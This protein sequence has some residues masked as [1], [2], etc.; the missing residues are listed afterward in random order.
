MTDEQAEPLAHL[1]RTLEI[2]LRAEGV[3]A[4]VRERIVSRMVFGTPDGPHRIRRY[5]TLGWP[6][7]NRFFAAW[8]NAR[9]SITADPPSPLKPPACPGCGEPAVIVTG[10]AVLPGW[11]EVRPCGCLFD[12]GT[13][14]PQPS[15]GTPVAP[16]A[17]LPIDRPPE[18]PPGISRETTAALRQAMERE[19]LR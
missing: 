15:Y 9:G 18:P 16:T 19:G 11:F 7:A 6:E 1:E 3:A 10:A 8:E 13:R 5:R 14:G 2:T 4:D 12:V 17:F